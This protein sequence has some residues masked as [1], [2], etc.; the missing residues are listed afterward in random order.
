MSHSPA[1]PTRLLIPPSCLSL[2]HLFL[3]SFPSITVTHLCKSFPW[4]TG[5]HCTAPGR[6]QEPLTAQH[7]QQS[8]KFS[9]QTAEHTAGTHLQHEKRHF[10]RDTCFLRGSVNL[11]TLIRTIPLTL[12]CCSE[13]GSGNTLGIQVISPL[14]KKET[15]KVIL[16]VLIDHWLSHNTFQSKIFCS[17]T[18]CQTLNLLLNKA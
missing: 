7:R 11:N 16:F 8:K 5:W 3:P 17:R 12:A 13:R 10:W 4:G 2:A 15:C 9:C 18:L 14:L 6:V 1:L